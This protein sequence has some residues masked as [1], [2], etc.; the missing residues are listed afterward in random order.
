MIIAIDRII[1]NYYILC[2]SSNKNFTDSGLTYFGKSLVNLP[3]LKSI[4]LH[5]QE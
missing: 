3:A 1:L 5:F 2:F 4:S